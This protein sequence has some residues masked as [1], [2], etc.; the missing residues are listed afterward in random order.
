MLLLL[1]FRLRFQA[2]DPDET[3]EDHQ[4]PLLVMLL[5]SP[6]LFR[7]PPGRAK[8]EVTTLV[9]ATVNTLLHATAGYRIYDAHFQEP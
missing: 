3:E 2:L 7:R 4:Y 1:L 9:S 6:L 5:K 8:A